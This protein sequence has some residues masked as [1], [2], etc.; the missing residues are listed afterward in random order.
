MLGDGRNLFRRSSV[1]DTHT[2]ESADPLTHTHTQCVPNL[3]ELSLNHHPCQ[4]C[5]L[6]VSEDSVFSLRTGLVRGRQEAGRSFAADRVPTVLGTLSYTDGGI[7][8]TADGS[9]WFRSSDFRRRLGILALTLDCLPRAR[10][11]EGRGRCLSSAAVR[12]HLRLDG[13]NDRTFPSYFWRL[14]CH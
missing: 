9:A 5:L 6:A 11:A 7:P 1:S 13:L 3:R 4:R 14:S 8:R 2:K 12:K 10:W